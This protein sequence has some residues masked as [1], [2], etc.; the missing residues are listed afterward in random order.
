MAM[1]S[2]GG[3]LNSE[4]NVTPMVDVMLVLLIIFMITAPLINQ[5]GVE[6]DLP[7]V[8]AQNIDDPNGPL[9]VEID[10]KGHLSLNGTQ[11]LWKDLT[12]KL[13]A[14]PK[15][16]HDNAVYISADTH[17]PYG[18]IIAAMAIIKNAGVE[19][20]MFLTD[21]GATLK[22]EDLDNAAAK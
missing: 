22:P 18:T 9:K 16:Q 1:S 11:L 12:V 13:K 8:E 19:K 2:G 20:V 15:V 5:T 10:P 4:I 7:K 21:P 14:N 17:L 6:M 3:D